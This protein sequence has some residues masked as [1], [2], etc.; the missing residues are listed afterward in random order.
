MRALA[1]LMVSLLIACGTSPRSWEELR[2]AHPPARCALDA[3]APIPE[4][5][6]E[7]A[8]GENVVLVL[9]ISHS[10][11]LA[12]GLDV[13][14]DGLTGQNPQL[15][16]DRF[17]NPADILSTDPGDT[18]LALEVQIACELVRR[19]SRLGNRVALV[20]FS[21]SVDRDRDERE[22]ARIVVPSTHSASAIASGLNRI[23]A[24]EGW[25][26]TNYE[27]AI[28]TALDAVAGDPGRTRIV[29]VTDG[30]PTL[31]HG[32]PNRADPDDYLAA[33]NAAERAAAS[34]AR[35]DILVVGH[36]VAPFPG[37]LGPIAGSGGGHAILFR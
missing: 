26:G 24:E 12:S 18:H 21:G 10:A 16:F 1:A 31:P 33:R 5:R 35:L 30:R 6:V 27:A 28:S 11:L 8:P 2:A 37:K 36:R 22:D 13:D 4:P 17:G 9:D 20:S 32:D 3:P 23:L 19:S 15:L 25:G 29:I 7:L 34:G 14:G